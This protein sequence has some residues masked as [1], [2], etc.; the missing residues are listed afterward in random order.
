[1]VIKNGRL[2]WAP[3]SAHAEVWKRPPEILLCSLQ[4]KQIETWR[5]LN[6]WADGID[7][8]IFT[9]DDP[10]SV[11]RNMFT[12]V[13][14]APKTGMCPHML[15]NVPSSIKPQ[16]DAL[17]ASTSGFSIDLG[18]PARWYLHAVKIL[19]RALRGKACAW[20]Q[21]ES[22]HSLGACTMAAEMSPDVVVAYSAKAM[23]DSIGSLAAGKAGVNVKTLGSIHG[24]QA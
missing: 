19:A 16:L 24:E 14:F 8:I 11:V 23:I 21:P 15:V 6:R 9:D 1:M 12:C 22:D 17:C 10:P 3:P 18:N 5:N 7:M 20:I 4:P 13:A 2:L